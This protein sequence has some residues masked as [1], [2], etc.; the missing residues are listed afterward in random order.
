MAKSYEEVGEWEQAVQAYQ[1]YLNYPD[2]EIPGDPNAYRTAQENVLFYYYPDKNW[3]VPD[4]NVLVAAVKDAIMTKSLSKLMKYQAKV[5]FYQGGWDQQALFGDPTGEGFTAFNIG[6]YLASS[7]PK[8]DSQLDIAA[9]DREAYL[10]STDWNFRP[11]TW[12]LYFRRVDFPANPDINGQWEWAGIYFG[13]K[14]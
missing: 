5:N 7:Y 9:N 13:E 11:P 3:M 2:T 12:Y 10:R 8:I 4:L 14:I 1:K 6:T